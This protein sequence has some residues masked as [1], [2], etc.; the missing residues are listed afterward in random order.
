MK[1]TIVILGIVFLVF[2]CKS[3]DSQ[4]EVSTADADSAVSV[5]SSLSEN[6]LHTIMESIPSPLE[7][8]SLILNS[9][10]PYSESILNNNEN[11]SKYN[12]EFSKAV[13][14]GIFG[15]DLGYV[16][17]YEKTFSS[18]DYLNSVYK[19]STDLNV[20]EFFDFNTL[21]RLAT[22]NQNLDSIVYITTSG[23]EKM[24]RHLKKM[25]NTQIGVLM[26]VGGWIEGLYLTTEIIQIAKPSQANELK[27]T[28]YDEH[29]V[30]TDILKLT[31]AFK[32]NPNFND[33]NT[34]LNTLNNVY[35][36]IPDS[37]N[38]QNATAKDKHFNELVAQ[39]KSIR[40][41][42]IQ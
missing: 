32:S 4:K 22:N 35:S 6:E 12:S 25:N 30:L 28:V 10:A 42:L 13:N 20:G 24:Q 26:I 2:G 5:T 37:A 7:L 29:I 1:K 39:I 41:K 17:L 21:K 36:S 23:F 16:N 40:N 15:A 33:L 19:L 34:S 3:T 11:L 9:G 38:G 31:E 27:L 14:L 18:M 8:S